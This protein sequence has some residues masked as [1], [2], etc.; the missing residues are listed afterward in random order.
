MYLGVLP[1][2]MYA[3]CLK[4]PEEDVRSCGKWNYSW[5]RAVLWVLGIVPGSVAL[6]TCKKKHG[7]GLEN[8]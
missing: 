6:A 4:R 5:L 2:Y 1:A 8:V 7:E 3:C